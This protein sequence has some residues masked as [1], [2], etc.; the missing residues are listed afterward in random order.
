MRWRVA[1]AL[2]IAA[3]ALCLIVIL[4]G[5]AKAHDHYPPACCGGGPNG[6]C[7]PISVENFSETQAGWQ[8]DFCSNTRPGLCI[9]GFVKR[10]TE[11]PSEEGGYHLCF[12][13][14]RIICFFEPR[15]S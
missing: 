3:A 11:K 2:L 1:L 7:E 15:G 9:S 5:I 6:D 12:N 10:G 13:S 8:V 14:S 4:S